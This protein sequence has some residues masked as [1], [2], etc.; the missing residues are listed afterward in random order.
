MFLKDYKKNKCVRVKWLTQQFVRL[1]E[2][3]ELTQV[4]KSVK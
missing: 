1:R 3:I 2:A 4:R